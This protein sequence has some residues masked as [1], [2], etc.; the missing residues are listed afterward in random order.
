MLWEEET[1][2]EEDQSMEEGGEEGEREEE[3]SRQ[4]L[5]MRSG[6]GVV[7]VEDMGKV[8]H[9]A[10]VPHAGGEVEIKRRVEPREM[11]TPL[12]RNTMCVQ[13]LQAV[14][15]GTALPLHRGESLRVR[16][17]NVHYTCICTCICM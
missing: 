11:V 8:L 10:R 13:L 15:K 1:S 5:P 2:D 7:H 16:P 6:A 4:K 12:L 17:M 9:R 3:R 14:L